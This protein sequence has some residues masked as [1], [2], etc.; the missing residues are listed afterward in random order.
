MSKE[1]Y[2]KGFCKVAAAAGVD[3]VALAK[4]AQNTPLQGE[5]LHKAVQM[6]VENGSIDTR[7][8][9]PLP[10][11][12]RPRAEVHYEPSFTGYT[13]TRDGH[14]IPL[15]RTAPKRNAVQTVANNDRFLQ[16]LKRISKGVLR[17]MKKNIKKRR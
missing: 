1:S 5:E 13:T 7:N 3:P 17:D 16:A 9:P 12:A 4:F 10:E 2:A 6:M 8:Y 15:G 11:G 14:R